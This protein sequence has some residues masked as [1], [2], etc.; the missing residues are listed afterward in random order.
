MSAE[1]RKTAPE[2]SLNVPVLPEAPAMGERRARWG[3]GYQDKVATA[4]VLDALRSDLR[5]GA[6]SLECV[7]LADLKAGRVDD[8][9][10]VFETEVSGHSIKW[11]QVAPAMNWSDLIGSQGL[12]RELAQGWTRLRESHSG[13]TVTVLL[14]TNRPASTAAHPS[15]LIRE[16]S[17]ADFFLQRWPS[18]PTSADEST[19]QAAW[20]QI[21]A[22]VGLAGEQFAAFVKACRVRFAY[23]QPPHLERDSQDQRAYLKQFRELHRAF[24]TW[25]TDNPEGEL[26][27][28]AYLLDAI[29]FS[30]FRSGL[31]QRF[32][33]PEIPYERNHGAAAQIE[34]AIAAVSGGYLAVTGPAG[35]GKS[36]LVQDVLS[37]HPFFIP[38]FAYLPDGIGNPR[39]RGEALTFFQDIVLRLDYFFEGRRSLGITDIAQGR[40]AL[41]DHMQRASVLFRKSG[42]KTVLLIDGLDHVQREAGLEKPLLLELPR[43]DEVPDGFVIILSSQPQAL[44]ADVVERHVS[45]VLSSTPD[46]CIEVE[47]LSREEIHFIVQDARADLLYGERDALALG[48]HGNPLILTYL[49]RHL[50][51]YPGKSVADVLAA[52]AEYAGDIERYYHSALAVPLRSRETKQILALISRASSPLPVAWVNRWPEHAAFESVYETTLAPFVRI[53]GD[54]LFFIH[55]SLQSFL[56]NATR[57]SL[58]GVDHEEEERQFHALLAERCGERPCSDPIGRAKIFHL[59]R[60]GK[61]QEL[62]AALSSPWLRRGVEAFLPDATL[63]PLLLSGLATAWK[64]SAFGEV[65]R[66]IFLEFECGQRAARLAAGDIV[67]E[68]LRLDQP[69]LAA[70]QVRS[71]GRVLLDHKHAL[72]AAGDLQRFAFDHDDSAIRKVATTIYLQCKPLNFIYRSEP[73]D[74]HTRRQAVEDLD[75]WAKIAPL[76]EEPAAIARQIQ[77][78]KFAPATSEWEQSES[79]IKA[80]LLYDATLAALQEGATTGDCFPLLSALARMRSWVLYFAALLSVYEEYPN[81]ALLRKLIKHRSRLKAHPDLDLR[82]AE[83]LFNAGRVQAA[84]FLCKTLHHLP[85]DGYRN[86]HAFGLSDIS[87][88]VRLTRL[89][90]R[91]GLEESA[92]PEVTD[93][94][95]EALARIETASR[96]LGVLIGKAQRSDVPPDL[97]E[98][99]RSL[100]LFHNRP[101]RLPRFGVHSNYRINQSKL[102]IYRY[103]TE[104]AELFGTLGASSLREA[105]DQVLDS[106]AGEQFNPLHR[107]LFAEF[108]FKKGAL[109]SLS[110]ATLGLSRLNDSSDD[111][112]AERQRACLEIA[113]FL[114]A[115]GDSDRSKL[116]FER[117]GSV[118]A[119]AGNHKDYHMTQLADWLILACG[120]SLD[121]RKFALVEKFLRALEVAGGDGAWRATA[122]ILRHLLHWAPER[123][124]KLATELIDREMLNLA[125][126]LEALLLGAV[127]AGASSRL[128]ISAYCDLLTLIDPGY[129]TEVALAILRLVPLAQR[130]EVAQEL[131]AAVRVNALSRNRIPVARA[132][133][134]A[135]AEDGFGVIDLASGLPAGRDDSSDKSSLYRLAT[136][137]L[138]SVRQVAARL[139]DP[140]NPALWNPNPAENDG[141]SWWRAIR[142]ADVTNLAHAERL[143]Q[144]FAVP[145]YENVDLLGWKSRIAFKAGDLLMARQLADKAFEASKRGSWF[146]QMDGAQLRLAFQALMPFDKAATLRAARERFGRDLAGG[147][148]W[149]IFLLDDAPE[150]LKFLEIEWPGEAVLSLIEEH[151]D[152]VLAVSRSVP[153][154]QSFVCSAEQATSDAALCRFMLH[155]L[156]FPV[157]DVSVGSRRALARFANGSADGTALILNEGRHCEAV[158]VEHLLAAVQTG[159]HRTRP[160]LAPFRTKLQELNMHESAAVRAIARRICQTQGWIWSEVR[161][162]PLRVGLVLP[163]SHASSSESEHLM[164]AQQLRSVIASLAGLVIRVLERSGNDGEELRSELQQEFWKLEANYT[165]ADD[166]R[167][168][169]WVAE[170]RA[171]TWLNPRAIVGREAA[172]R[173]L[174]KRALSGKAPIWTEEGY[175]FFYPI[176]DP[177]LELIR[178]MERPDEVST[179]DWGITRDDA[180]MVWL[181]GTDAADWRHYPRKIGNLHILGE[182][183]TLMRPDWERPREQRYRGILS[184]P[185]HAGDEEDRCASLDALTYEQYLNGNGQRNEQLTVWNQARQ[186]AGSAYRWVAF[187]AGIARSIGWVASDVNPFEWHDGSGNLMVKSVLWRDGW[188]DLKSPHLDAVAEGWIVLASN[189][190]IQAIIQSVPDASQH[191]WVQRESHG[192]HPYED[193]WHLSCS[194]DDML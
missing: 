114:K 90:H 160:E 33:I 73:I 154:F 57:A 34:R 113:A 124:S 139:S 4:E 169:Q 19:L 11:S 26:I 128:L 163:E 66:L 40:E 65:M 189:A 49:L 184:G 75:L 86:E 23:P 99:F 122:D 171:H 13:K 133:Q 188:I 89:R 134:D 147:T 126:T 67:R 63:R 143:L 9:V 127:D 174:G 116:W 149:S 150:I 78:L 182:R 76:F 71:N 145:D 136:G 91:L 12:M 52:A 94:D 62:L 14:Q 106:P 80:S 17:V 10:L 101:V 179:L 172:M 115:L 27:D 56:R 132:L 53:E 97:K 48:C 41:R 8:F 38:Y 108:L 138:L 35:V 109:D 186:L 157:E 181:S 82:F 30:S 96:Q 93:E 193:S 83:L 42:F 173:L 192:R 51:I 36:T 1:P 140:A 111:D 148:L 54:N 167:L 155:L 6:T 69:T 68:L 85:V 18:G 168:R 117:A 166:R 137:E 47:G 180:Q 20:Q 58:P 178:P 170:A 105:L 121:A 61:N 100:L 125:Q 165:W 92:V 81:E 141:F 46:R 60:A 151:V 95:R 3:Y 39:D 72:P 74:G 112:P 44:L 37:Q 43:P 159:L 87:Y 64:L 164:P 98:Q 187:N 162:L 21:S 31:E 135:L 177:H 123:A 110:A 15:Q 25:L 7:R 153:P 131:V 176:Y 24:A 32:P 130:V 45:G 29:G 119:G 190:A 129:S 88:T 175:D 191:L 50:K 28:R 59:S 118:T 152:N 104:V 2:P 185:V 22:H 120:S 144:T 55:N 158:Q 156:A 183:T 102:N 84:D 161:N 103:I 70:D 142:S 5:N 77:Q 16:F 194:L 79:S 146:Q 107:R